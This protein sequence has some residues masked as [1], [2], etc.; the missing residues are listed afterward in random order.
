M[1]RSFAECRSPD[2][3]QLRRA[4]RRGL[5]GAFK[6]AFKTRYCC[7]RWGRLTR[8]CGE[9]AGAAPFAAFSAC[10]PESGCCG[11]CDWAI[12]PAGG[13]RLALLPLNIPNFASRPSSNKTTNRA[14]ICPTFQPPILSPI[15]TRVIFGCCPT[16]TRARAV[17]PSMMTPSSA[18]SGGGGGGG[19]VGTI[20]GGG[21]GGRRV[22]EKSGRS[23]VADNWLSGCC[24]ANGLTGAAPG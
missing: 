17:S 24:A 13:N 1:E 4:S 23:R 19:A 11:P 6:D 20:T 7:C 3:C 8:G 9:L 16:R 12:A 18:T 22:G 21:A 14:S 5:Q 10:G 15:W 2:E